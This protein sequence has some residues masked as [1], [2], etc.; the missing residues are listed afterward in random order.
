MSLSSDDTPTGPIAGVRQAPSGPPPADARPAAY[1]GPEAPDHLTKRR[2]AGRD[3]SAF[4]LLLLAP[5]FPWNLYFGL[6]IPDSSTLL[7][8]LL[9]AVTL[10]SLLPLALSRGRVSANRLRVILNAPYL[11]LV[12][13]FVV[14]DVWESIKIGG[15]AYVPGG[16]GPGGWL[17]FAGAL[18]S[19]QPVLGRPV[20]DENLY[21]R[22]LRLARLIGYASMFGAS[23][24]AGFHLCW[25]LR[26]ALVDSNGSASFGTRNIAV[27]LTAVVYGAVALAAV[28]VASRWVLRNAVG[29]RLPTL[30][31]GGSTLLAG[32]IVWALPAGREIDAFHGIAQNTSTAGVGYEGYLAWAGAAAIFAPM[33]L[34]SSGE[35]RNDRE[36]WRTAIRK[37]LALIIVWCLGSVLMR[38]T[39]L[40]VEMLLNYPYSRYDISMLAVFNL[41]AA[42]LAWWL[43]AKLADGALRSR[44]LV[45]LSGLVFALMI[46]RVILGV[47]LAPRF[48][49]PS[50]GPVYGNDLA[51]QIDS[52]FDVALCG[53][54]LCVL[55]AIIVAGRI[56]KPRRPR[57]RGP[58]QRPAAGASGP[59]RPRVPL[60][61]RPGGPPPPSEARTTQ[62]GAAGSDAPTSVL[63]GH[64]QAPR[65]AAPG[66]GAPRPKIYRPPGNPS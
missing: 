35:T 54:A 55:V 32:M 58:V 50:V 30:W 61:T 43:R 22:W 3:L 53:L 66:E 33:A 10:L 28:L 62:F 1:A 6:G 48:A 57:R 18:L 2:N 4:A 20:I 47:L 26:Y 25:R 27:I 14:F 49:Q 59:G 41:T 46:S 65:A 31:L 40:A 51:Q 17:G 16:V 36:I 60:P 45:W 13:G 23:L 8:V 64:G 24:S 19:A 63:S 7:W 12:V 37:A 11:L 29:S 21:H 5:L 42:M 52:T 9:G 38:L 44:L 56:R 34:F 39:D 15:K